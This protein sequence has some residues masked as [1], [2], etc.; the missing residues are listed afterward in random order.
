MRKKDLQVQEINITENQEDTIQPKRRPQLKTSLMEILTI[1]LMLI[2]GCILT[3]TV[4]DLYIFKTYGET[5][6][7]LNRTIKDIVPLLQTKSM[8]EN[9]FYDDYDENILLDSAISGYVSALGDKY[10]RYENPQEQEKSQIKNDGKAVGIGITIKQLENN[11][12][13]IEEVTDNTPAQRAGLKKGDIIKSISGKD[14][15]EYGFSESINLIKSGEQN[16][17]IDVTI[18]RGEQELNITIDRT[19]IEVN[20]VDGKMLDNDIGYIRISHF[21]TNTPEQFNEVYQELVSQGAKGFIFDL[22]NNTGGYTQSVQGCL[23]DLLPK[24][25]IAEATYKDGSKS[26]I[27]KSD[28]DK[29]IEVPSVVIT[30]GMTASAGEIF[31]SAMREFANSKLVGENTFGKGVMQSTHILSNG[32][33]LVLTVATYNIVDRECYHGIGLAPDYEVILDESATEDLQLNKSIEVITDLI[34]Q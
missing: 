9:T 17:T 28:S 1:I 21:Y 34:N 5:I 6:I 27:V 12:M 30:N 32:G 16:T 4:L 19:L 18:L 22:R 31:S 23:N 8:V 24:G 15:A 7:S 29:V 33:A 20:S 25:D 11:Y 3:L 14:V 10:S 13:Q 26:V 2:S